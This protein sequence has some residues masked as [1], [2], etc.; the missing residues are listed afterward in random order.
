VSV[1]VV[2]EVIADWMPYDDAKV[3]PFERERG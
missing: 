1:A 3:V 2:I